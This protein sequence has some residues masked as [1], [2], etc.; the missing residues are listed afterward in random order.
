MICQKKMAF[1]A[2]VAMQAVVAQSA[3][4]FLAAASIARADTPRADTEG[5]LEEIVVTAEKREST[6]LKTPFSMTAFSSQQLVEQGLSRIEDLASET[7]GLSMKQFSPGETDY[8]IRGLPAS[9]GSS[10]T[11][12]LYLNDVPMASSA[13]S[14]NGKSSIDP[15]LFDLQ[16]VEVLRGPQGTLYG[17]GSMGGTI[18]LI[19]APPVFNQFEALSQTDLSGTHGGGPN[20]G[21][22]VMLNVP[23]IDDKLAIRI[24]GT[25]KYNDGWVD[26]IVVS[27]FPIGTTGACG[28]PTCT[29]GAVNNAPIVAQY[30]RSNWDRLQGGRATVRY[31]PTDDLTIDLMSMYQGLRL[32]GF[33][34]VDQS[35]GISALDTYSPVDEPLQFLDTFKLNS[36]A[37]NYDLHFAKLTSDTAN[38]IHQDSWTADTAEPTEYTL[39]YFYGFSPFVSSPLTNSDRTKQFSEELRLT[40]E[41]TSRVQWV[42]GLFFSN[43]TSTIFSYDADPA[44]AVLS[45]GGPPANPGGLLYRS[46]QPYNLKQYAVFAEGSYLIADGWKATIGARGFRYDT[47]LDYTQAGITASTG[48][49]TPQS[50]S[51][52]SSASGVNPKLNLSYSPTENLNWY[53]EIA[54]GFRPGGVNLPAPADVCS[55]TDPISYD[56]DSIWN[57]EVGEKAR[58]MGG[59]LTVNADLYYIRWNNVQQT[60][61]LP[62]SYPFTANIGN[63]ETY[64]PE[65]EV[66]AKV[67]DSVT[68]TLAGSYVTARIT[69]IE[70]ALLGN[71]VGSTEIL[72]PG[73]PVLNI[74]KYDVSAAIDWSHSLSDTY[75]VTARLSETTTGPFYDINYYVQS[76]P[77]YTLADARIGVVGG[78]WATY[79]Y[80][81][82]LTNKIAI[83]TIDTHAYSFP[84]PPLTTPS[85]STPR[86][87]GMQINYKF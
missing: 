73:I 11:V 1:I 62:C 66:A 82:N 12:G 20:W 16:R 81:H 84:V 41:G 67:S 75:K 17:A 78:Q 38:W 70:P 24:V 13:N 65:L 51:V 37:I 35:V 85:V 23:L 54:K 46:Y 52:S 3:I 7:P 76:L 83:L 60:L 80:A 31:Q 55:K 14:F 48:N 72:K 69:S 56:P 6:V 25:D 61:T 59:R 32:G 21:E 10:A 19:T 64:G 26:R 74:P 53:A 63:A 40:S 42:G 57:Y 43:L 30:N 50:G 86:T 27:P 44:F 8:E 45:T 47:G 39:N 15:D 36:L 68:L 29:R 22:S 87:I 9:G 28:W 79:L 18:R 33:P 49:A 58:L 71:A 34:Q 5:S 4:G 2:V 77:G